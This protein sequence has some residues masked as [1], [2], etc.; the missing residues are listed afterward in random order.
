MEIPVA[1]LTLVMSLVTLP[2]GSGYEQL[3]SIAWA[4]EGEVSY[5]APLYYGESSIDAARIVGCTVVNRV[6]S[7][8]FPS[9]PYEVVTQPEQY[10]PT[11]WVES[12]SYASVWI[13]LEVYS[14]PGYH[15]AHGAVFVFSRTD[16]RNLNWLLRR[17]AAV[18][19]VERDSWGIYGFDRYPGDI[20][21]A[22]IIAFLDIGLVP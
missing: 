16:L 11:R 3:A 2:S 8:Y 13:A 10:N 20:S 6:V 12:V 4:I 17:H 22:E 14:D 1:I 5:T 21:L 19:V 9:T 7:P 15:C 18:A